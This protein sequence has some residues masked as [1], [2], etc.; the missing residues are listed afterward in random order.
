VQGFLDAAYDGNYAQASNY[1]FLEHLPKDEQGKKGPKL[2]RRLRFV[3][4]RKLWIDLGAVTKE[5]KPE[6]RYEV[7][8]SIPLKHTKQ[9]IRLRR[10]AV[11]DGHA[12]VFSDDTVRAIDPLFEA[13]GP[14]FAETLP[15][16]LFENSL[17]SLELWQ[18]L[19]LFFLAAGA[20]LAALLVQKIVI[21]VGLRMAKLTAAGW[22][23]QLVASGRGPLRL[24]VFAILF[25]IGTRVLLLP[26]EAQKVSD[27]VVKSLLVFAMAWYLLR[28]LRVGADYLL[29]RD[30]PDANDLR[31]RSL[32]TQVAVLR[33]VVEVAVWLIGAAFLLMQFEL[34]RNI[35]V[36]LLASAGIAGLVLGFA[37]QKSISTL[38]AGIQLSITQPIRI[39]DQ[40][41][42]EG[43]W[44]TVEEI[45]LTYVVVRVWDLRRLIIPITQFLEKPFQ[46]WTRTSADLL[47]TVTLEV[48][49]FADVDAVRAELARILEGERAKK[50]WDGKLQIVSITEALDRSM[51]LRVLVS[52]ASA[53]NLWDLRCLVREGLLKFLRGHP[54]WLPTRRNENRVVDSPTSGDDDRRPQRSR[55][56]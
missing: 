4:D 5:P 49:F 42:I 28:A 38:L 10:V 23:D 3:L 20:V 22:D 56:G 15:E 53:G 26:P 34:V 12:W 37:A 18:W 6:A 30:S 52:A 32:R 7:L 25:A 19:G 48:D 9:S 51:T 35:G 41:V 14:P 13:Y 33:R 50:L 39:G 24:P 54:E 1:L 16:A 2:A 43:E 8:G 21:G 45:R 44:G 29:S 31:A 27:A 47:G 55:S 36:S 46:N 17:G 11:G 40:V